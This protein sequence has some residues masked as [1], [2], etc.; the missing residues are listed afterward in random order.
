MR[1]GARGKAHGHLGEGP[2]PE[3]GRADLLAGGCVCAVVG[4][5]AGE[6]VVGVVV[7]A[8]DPG[9]RTRVDVV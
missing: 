8:L 6:L 4:A 1:R 7:A 5:A 9:L 3:R 2:G